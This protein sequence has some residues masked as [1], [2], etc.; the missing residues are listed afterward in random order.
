M[1]NRTL[2]PEAT[3][4]LRIQL[5]KL[6]RLEQ[7][8]MDGL[9]SLVDGRM[10]RDA[11]LGLLDEQSAAHKAWQLKSCRYFSETCE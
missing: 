5:D 7:R 10:T 4:D 9:Q 1:I 3:L 6:K 11:Y 8:C 2:P